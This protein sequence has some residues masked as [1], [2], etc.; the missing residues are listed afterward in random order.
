MG[1]TSGNAIYFPDEKLKNRLSMLSQDELITLVAGLYRHY[2]EVRSMVNKAV[3]TRDDAD[4]VLS[5]MDEYTP[6]ECKTALAA[7]VKTIRDRKERVLYYFGFIEWVLDR[8]NTIDHRFISVASASYGKVMDVLEID[9]KLWDELLDKSYAI[10]TR[11]YEMDGAVPYKA[12]EYY[13]RVK[14]G[15]D[16]A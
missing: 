8:K 9:K 6:G 11:F 12:M 16:K 5:H 3:I 4:D 13:V 10:A 14:R 1:Y 15:F 7:H 2:P